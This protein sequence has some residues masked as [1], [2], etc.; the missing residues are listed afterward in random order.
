MRRGGAKWAD[1][2]DGAIAASIADMELGTPPFVVDAVIA[3]ARAGG[4]YASP[5]QERRT[6]DAAARWWRRH[7]L[8]MDTSRCIPVSSVT[9]TVAFTLVRTSK[10]GDGVVRIR[11]TYP[12]FVDLVTASDRRDLPVDLVRGTQGWELD[13]DALEAACADARIL[14]WVAPH[15]P[16]GRVWREEEVAAVA[17]IAARHGLVVISDEIWA[18]VLLDGHDHVPFEPVAREV[19]WQLMERTVTIVGTSKAWN[20]A[21]TAAA[22]VH[23]DSDELWRRLHGP[24]HVPLLAR[25]TRT[26][27][28]A[29]TAAWRE[30]QE[31]LADTLEV[32]GGNV[33][34]AVTAWT[35]AF[36]AARVTRPQGTYLVWLD[37]RGLVPG[38]DPM[39]VL[40]VP[41]GVVPSDGA[42]FGAPG[43]VRCNLAT[44]SEEA[45]SIVARVT[46]LVSQ[47]A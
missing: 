22:V 25:P 13:L 6:V 14:L 29:A 41:D 38:D 1:V 35:Q 31:W 33:D 30:G 37:L 16:T 17:E 12:P 43:F 18:D 10:P 11:P 20:L 39:S 15:N 19:D 32:I 40:A 42:L 23:T 27:L 4:G 47:S 9:P 7:G 44:T 2:P 21:D 8:V 24:G 3:E 5:V 26:A 45:A 36:G 46:A 34:H 28:Q